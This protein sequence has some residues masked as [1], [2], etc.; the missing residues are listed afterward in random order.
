MNMKYVIVTPVR[1]EENHL[2]KT[3]ESGVIQTLR[4]AEWV[5]VNDGSTDRT[6]EIIEEYAREY[7]WIRGIQKNSWDAN[8]EIQ[9]YQQENSNSCRY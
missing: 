2:R 5:I 3:L 4:P 9:P 7:P 6:G 1:D 8:P